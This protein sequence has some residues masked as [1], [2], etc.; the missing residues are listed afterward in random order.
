MIRCMIIDDEPVARDIIRQFVEDT[1]FLELS[2]EAS[3]AVE[4]MD[5]LR[6]TTVDLLFLDINM[7]GLSGIQFLKSISQPPKV[8]LTTAYSEYALESYELDVVD[9]LLKPIRFERFLKAV[10]KVRD[11]GSLPENN[12][13]TFKSDGKLIRLPVNEL[14]YVEGM[15]DYIRLH[16]KDQRYTVYDT[17]KSMSF[18]LEGQGF[19]RIHK[20]FL[21]SLSNVQ[22]VEGNRVTVGGVELPIGKAY[23]QDF[24]ERFLGK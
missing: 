6:Q 22:Y 4:A 9:Y 19:I 1:P 7:P 13:L 24:L 23:K 5:L 21:I 11:S 3:S 17:M 12:N 16:T 15:G 14:Q 10:N 18:Q 2:S 8:I 20:S